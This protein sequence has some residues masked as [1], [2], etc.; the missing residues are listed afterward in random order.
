MKNMFVY[1]S[2][3]KGF[4]NH[5]LIEDNPRNKLIRKASISGYKLYLL[6]SHPGI[7]PSIKEDKI[8]VELY[9]LTDEVFSKIDKMEQQAGYTP[10]EAEDD[11]GNKG[12]VY[13]YD[14]EVGEE[15]IISF[16][17]WTKEDEKLKIIGDKDDK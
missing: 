8:F 5:F 7:K 10:V 13:V 16:G 4:F 17:K 1:G 9:N 12:I 14:R 2:L 11:E 15:N 3:K 6:W